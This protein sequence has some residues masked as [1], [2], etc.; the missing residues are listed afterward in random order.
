MPRV[1]VPLTWK[2]KQFAVLEPMGMV[3]RLYALAVTGFVAGP[4]AVYSSPYGAGPHTLIHLPSQTK[5]IDLR[6]QSACKD[7][8]EKFAALDINWWTCIREEV[9]GPDTQEIRNIYDRLKPHSWVYRE[10]RKA[11]DP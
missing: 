11:G 4:F 6:L 2:R 9:I 7:A 8:A 5:I 3:D 1:P 10:E